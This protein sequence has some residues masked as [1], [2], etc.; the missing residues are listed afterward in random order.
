MQSEVPSILFIVL[1][2]INNHVAVTLED[3]KSNSKMEFLGI[4]SISG[5]EF[6]LYL[7]SFFRENLVHHPKRLKF[8]SIFLS[9]FLYPQEM[10]GGTSLLWSS[11]KKLV[12]QIL[13]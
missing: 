8:L 9:M 2:L 4:F 6:L 13:L 10:G 11:S 3:G 5:F 1:L 7:L 12:A